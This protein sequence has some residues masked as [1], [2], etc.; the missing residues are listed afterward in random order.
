MGFEWA[1]AQP[2]SDHAVSPQPNDGVAVHRILAG[3]EEFHSATGS[4]ANPSRLH[5]PVA[6][7]GP[8]ETR[9]ESLCSQFLDLPQILR[10]MHSLPAPC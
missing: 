1:A 3:N 2:A 8:L 7:F 10:S 4:Q 5:A 6:F 9:A